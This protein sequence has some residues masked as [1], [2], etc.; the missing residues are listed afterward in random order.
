MVGMVFIDIANA[1][2]PLYRATCTANIAQVSFLVCLSISYGDI[3]HC[4]Q[5]SVQMCYIDIATIE[6]ITCCIAIFLCD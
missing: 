5:E 2:S 1:Y 4:K 6:E 3:E